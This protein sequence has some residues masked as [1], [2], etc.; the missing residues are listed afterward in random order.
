[1]KRFT[2]KKAG[3]YFNRVLDSNSESRPGLLNAWNDTFNRWFACDGYR[4]Y[5]INV[6]PDGV[7]EILG[8]NPRPGEYDSLHSKIEEMFDAQY[9]DNVTEIPVNQDEIT[10]AAK[11][12]DDFTIDLGTDFP[13]VNA[14][15]L[16]EAM[17]MLPNG[18]VYCQ[19][20]SR[21]MFSPVYVKSPDGI[22][23]ILPIR[24][25]CK[26]HWKYNG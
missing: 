2:A 21:R 20:N 25:E 16:R 6:F 26:F 5:R 12:K 8:L 18:K 14:R 13:V 17:E 23:L 24:R 9:I 11:N 10:A 3:R 4:A 22:A 15:Y 19:N 1:M 7:R